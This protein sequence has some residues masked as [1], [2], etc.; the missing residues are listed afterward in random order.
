MEVRNEFVS[1]GADGV[2]KAIDK[3]IRCG[4]GLDVRGGR[5]ALSIHS[6]IKLHGR[7]AAKIGKAEATELHRER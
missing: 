6:S 1:C 7:V 5:L 2:R 3:K 4:P